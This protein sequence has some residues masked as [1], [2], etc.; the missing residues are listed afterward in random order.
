[1]GLG[2]RPH[3]REVG[4]LER[5]IPGREL[6]S[7]D[8]V[9]HRHDAGDRRVERQRAARG[10]RLFEP[11]DLGPGNVPELQP[12][13]GGSDQIASRC[14][15]LGGS[16]ERLLRA[17]GEQV[18]ALHAQQLGAVDG[19]QR[20][21][22]PHLLA[23]EIH[24]ERLDEAVHL[25]VNLAYAGLVD[26]DAAN[27][28]PVAGRLP[29]ADL[30]RAQPD[31]L[32]AIRVDLDRGQALHRGR[33]RHFVVVDRDEVHPHL[34][35]ALHR[36]GL[37]GIH[38]RAV[39]RDLPLACIRG[40]AS[41][42]PSALDGNELHAADRAVARPVRGV[43]RVHRA[44]VALRAGCGD[45]RVAMLVGVR[46]SREVH[47]ASAERGSDSDSK[48]EPGEPAPRGLRP[49]RPRRLRPGLHL[50]LHI[51]FHTRLHIGPHIPLEVV[52]VVDDEV[53]ALLPVAP[54]APLPANPAP[55]EL[56]APGVGMA[57]SVSSRCAMTIRWA[58]ATEAR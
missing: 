4:D 8:D 56:P 42:A 19:E 13:A 46:R 45:C 15:E 57:S 20:L 2:L 5:R 30:G 38:R 37:R 14:R 31:E 7:L 1:M 55:P 51:G 44:L 11:V 53:P 16:A 26:G 9:L 58:S 3:L 33:A 50:R 36:R 49:L 34:V 29:G 48:Q 47:A 10:L 21:A 6:R 43:R 54:P 27:R 17:Q 22:A 18:L 24:R 12:P 25:D 40:L 23:H 28:A 52:V 35:L 41:G 32:L 39:E